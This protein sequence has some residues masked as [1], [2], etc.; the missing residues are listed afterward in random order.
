MAQSETGCP[1]S[2]LD[3]PLIQQDPHAFADSLPGGV[4]KV[5]EVGESMNEVNLF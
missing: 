1:G 2:L 5:L 4:G 3:V